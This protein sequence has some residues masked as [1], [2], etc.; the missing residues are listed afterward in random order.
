MKQ[1]CDWC[2]NQFDEYVSYHEEE[3][4]VPVYDDKIHFEKK[5]LI[6]L[7][8][9]IGFLCN[10]ITVVF[11]ILLILWIVYRITNRY[12]KKEY[13]KFLNADFVN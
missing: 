10:G 4:G 9:A 7:F 3:W 1:S 8:L 11:G 13:S 5:E 2:L 12:F 6:I